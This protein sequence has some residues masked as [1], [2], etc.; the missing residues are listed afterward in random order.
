VL[1]NL[2]GNLAVCHLVDRLNC[3]DASAQVDSL[4]TFLQLA[5]CLAGTEYQDGFRITNTRDDR[6]ISQD[7]QAWGALRIG[8]YLSIPTGFT[9]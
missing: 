6:V 3:F 7:P 5:L 9:L 8:A 1:S 4:K 2:C